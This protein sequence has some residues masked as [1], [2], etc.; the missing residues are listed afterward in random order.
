MYWTMGWVLTII[1]IIK[2]LVSSAGDLR[3][4][5]TL[6]KQD[7]SDSSILKTLSS[8]WWWTEHTRVISAF[9]WTWFKGCWIWILMIASNP[10]KFCSIRSLLTV[11][12]R[13]HL[14]RDRHWWRKSAVFLLSDNRTREH[15]LQGRQ[16]D[17]LPG[18]W[19][20][21]VHWRRPAEDKCWEQWLV[22]APHQM[23]CRPLPLFLSSCGWSDL[24]NN[25][26]I[27]Q[28]IHQ[29]CVCVGLLRVLWFSRH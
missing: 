11:S 6:W 2:A 7:P 20:G 25:S 23:D 9:W 24:N 1:S 5:S 18:C 15:F 28:S 22:Q 12:C 8:W 3:Q 19:I 27:N 10:L 21:G 13:A 26:L 29:F 4:G 16:S 14:R 17:H